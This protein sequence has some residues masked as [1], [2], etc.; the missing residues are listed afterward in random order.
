MGICLCSP[1]STKKYTLQS[2]KLVFGESID[3]R[4]TRKSFLYDAEI[5]EIAQLNVEEVQVIKQVNK[6]SNNE[7]NIVLVGDEKVGKSSIMIRYTK[8]IFEKHYIT[9]I[10]TECYTQSVT[11][12]DK[13]FTIKFFATAGNP[14]YM[15]DNDLYIGVADVLIFVFDFTNNESFKWLIDRINMAYLKT[16]KIIIIGN[17]VDL[18]KEVNVNS[19]KSLIKERKLE[20]LEVSAKTFLNLPKLINGSLEKLIF[21]DNNVVE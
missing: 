9:S 19:V 14:L 3:R 11:L 1:K 7:I 13:T 16:N 20:Y 8:G 15:A 5:K 17:K 4:K 10:Q 21:Q 6:S 18:K 2:T 12:R